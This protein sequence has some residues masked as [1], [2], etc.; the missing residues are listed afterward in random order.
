MA[1]VNGVNAANGSYS[2]VKD[3]VPADTKEYT[4]EEIK[5]FDFNKDG[6]LDES[7][8]SAINAYRDN[9]KFNS[10][11]KNIYAGNISEDTA[12]VFTELQQ[13]VANKMPNNDDGKNNIETV[14]KFSLKDIQNRIDTLQEG[15]QGGGGN[16]DTEDARIEEMFALQDLRHF[17]VAHQDELVQAPDKHTKADAN[18]A[19]ADAQIKVEADA[20][21]KAQEKQAALDELYSPIL[22]L[23]GSVSQAEK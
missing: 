20:I 2:K 17:V 8:H 6:K 5:L 16:P 12:I 19:K 23:L 13:N 22:S 4:A 18:A 1:E 15:L 14:R 11:I 9:N 21:Q 3:F 10:A 7:E